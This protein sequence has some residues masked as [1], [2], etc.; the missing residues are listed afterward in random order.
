MLPVPTNIANGSTVSLQCGMTYQ[1]TLNLSGKSNVTVTTSGTCGKASITPGTAVTSWSLYQGN[2]YS[3][4]IGFTPVQVSIDGKPIDT[5]HWPNR[6]QVWATSTSSIPSSDLTGATLITKPNVYSINS[7]TLSSNSV[8]TSSPF[9]VE[10]KLWML[11]SPGEWVVSN[12]RLYIWAPDGASPEGRV[13]AA[14]GNV[15]INA[16][17]SSGVTIDNVRVFSASDGISGAASTNLKVRNSEILNSA[18]DGVYAPD[19]ST[20]VL[21]SN[22]IANSVRNGIGGWYNN[23]GAIVTNNVVSTSGTVGMPKPTQAGIFFGYSSKNTKIDKNQVNNSASNGITAYVNSVISNNTVDSACTVLTDGGGIY[24]NGRTA[25]YVPLN[26]RIENNTV[27][28][29]ALDGAKGIYLDDASSYV[30]VTGNNVSAT[31]TGLF[32]HDGSNN[33]VTSNTFYSNVNNHVALGMTSSSNVFTGNN[34]NSTRNELTFALA[35]S[36]LTS[37]GTFDYNTYK[38]TNVSRFAS[39]AGTKD[40]TGWK[41]YM[42]QDTHSTLN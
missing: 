1:G 30:T 18:R 25:G 32:I 10:G 5:A 38:T 2:V 19:A 20:L 7:Q 42:R 35:G 4:P 8:S 6:P 39:A 37:Y 24:T 31:P 15:G 34:F 9:Y 28:N 22:A 12:G 40:Y 36:N 16:D 17:K 41:N 14:A 29:V 3:A 11:D 23:N 26:L 13:W 27:R 21:D 33:T